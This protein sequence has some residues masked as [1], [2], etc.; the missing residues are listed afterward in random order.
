MGVPD[1][2]H[3]TNRKGRQLKACVVAAVTAGV[4]A[5]GAG[6]AS[7][8]PGLPAAA[9]AGA[10]GPPGTITTAVGGVGGPAKATTVPV[11]GPLGVSFGAGHVYIAAVWC[12]W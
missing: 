10:A 6:Q 3:G 7:A 2:E 9:R 8:A 12:A 1:G 5:V 11:F 4:L